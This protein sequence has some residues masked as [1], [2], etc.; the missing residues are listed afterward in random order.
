MHFWNI[1][2]IMGAFVSGS[3]FSKVP[4]HDSAMP[5]GL[6]AK[7]PFETATG[8]SNGSIKNHLLGYSI[9]LSQC[10]HQGWHKHLFCH[11]LT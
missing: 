4:E 1:V 11:R 9:V 7:Q 3:N 6:I 10:S 2:R 8:I 5:F